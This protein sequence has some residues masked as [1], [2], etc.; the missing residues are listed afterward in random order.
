M[1]GR[2]DMRG[3]RL[4]PEDGAGRREMSSSKGV[5]GV[6]CRRRH[7]SWV[8]RLLLPKTFFDPFLSARQCIG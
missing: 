8:T 7:P 4:E 3:V 6:L 1:R 2:K 5:G